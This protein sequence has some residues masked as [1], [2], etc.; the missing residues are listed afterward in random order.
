[1]SGW[2]DPDLQYLAHVHRKEEEE[3]IAAEDRR[4]AAAGH[5]G[6]GK[7]AQMFA[8][9]VLAVLFA[10]AGAAIA[11]NQGADPAAGGLLGGLAGFFFKEL[12]VIAL[13]VGAIAF[14]ASLA[15]S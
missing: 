10:I 5:A 3:R 11:E 9:F 2:N 6:G 15:N 1:M 12:I 4:R 7:A 14:V 13:V 8:R